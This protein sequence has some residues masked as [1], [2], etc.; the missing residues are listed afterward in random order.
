MKKEKLFSGKKVTVMGLG[1]HG[2]GVG[3]AKFFYQE[4]AQVL[5]TDLKTKAQLEKSLK[6]LKKLKI[7]YR[8]G[9]HR[10][11]DFINTDLVVKNPAVPQSSHF[12]QVARDHNVQVATDIDIFFE[13]CKAQIIGV[14]GTKGKST[15]ATLIYEILRSKFRNTVLA[16]NIGVSPLEILG[17]INEKTKVVLELSSFELE[18][19][20]RS[21]NIAVIT[22]LYPD[23]LDR[24]ASYEEYIDAKKIIFK[25]QKPNDYLVLNYDNPQTRNFERGANANVYFFSNHFYLKR[26]G[27]N[28][29]CFVEDENVFFNNEKDPIFNVNQVKLSG[30]HNLSNLMAAVTVAKILEIPNDKIKRVVSKFQGV[31][32]R[33]QFVAEK[34][35]VRYVNDTTATMP[36]A[37]IQAL[38]TLKEEYP[39]SR[40]ILIAGGQD[41]NLEYKN[42][43]KEIVDKAVLLILLPGTASEKIKKELK[44]AGSRIQIVAVGSMQDAV[45]S[46]SATARDNDIVLL[47]PAAASFNIFK[48]EFD[49]GDQFVQA[50]KRIK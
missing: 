4:G 27:K 6:K 35:G 36:D 25:Y 38:K 10:E 20:K 30:E 14:T 5:V 32:N 12:L 22:S 39:Q 21:P 13:F 26:E 49:R 8:L 46:A 50:V 24:Y 42:L 23:H 9:E 3:V 34:R 43:A 41:K 33:Q 11:D 48:N 19:L 40:I 2:G 37:V 29:G 31:A 7:T 45:K 47:S 44:D 16:G 17:K 15:T 28:P 1:L 18:D